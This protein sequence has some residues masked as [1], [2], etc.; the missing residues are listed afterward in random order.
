VARTIADLAGEEEIR[1]A[2]LAEA[3]QYRG[4]KAGAVVPGMTRWLLLRRMSVFPVKGPW[5]PL[6]WAE[7]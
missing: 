7:P 5:G 2:H 1:Q 3:V 4:W 6:S